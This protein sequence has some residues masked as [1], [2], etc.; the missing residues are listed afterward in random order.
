M[1]DT[2][3]VKILGQDERVRGVILSYW[4]NTLRNLIIIAQ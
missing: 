3:C 2:R 1:M 4:N